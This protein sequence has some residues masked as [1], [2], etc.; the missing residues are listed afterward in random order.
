MPKGRYQVEYF[1]NPKMH[2]SR[3]IESIYEDVNAYS[4]EYF[5][6]EPQFHESIDFVVVL[7]PLEYSGQYAKGIFFS[8]GTDYLYKLHPQLGRLF[9]SIGNAQW[10]SIPWSTHA[11]G[12]FSL[13][14]NPKREQWFKD[15][16]PEK[17]SKVLVPLQDADYT[18]E[19]AMSPVPFVNKDIDIL[20]VSRLHDLKNIPIIAAALKVYRKKYKPIHMTM[21]LGKQV[22]LNLATLTD[23]ERKEWRQIESLLVHPFEYIT[24]VPYADYSRELPRYFSRSKL[25]VL[26]SLFEG[27]NRTLQEALCCNTPVVYFSEF[28]QYIRG[29]ASAVPEGSG[30]SAPQ[31]D[32]ES[33]ADTFHEVIENQGDFRP[34]REYLRTSGRKNFFNQTIDC[35]SHYYAAQLPEFQADAHTNNL[36]IDLAVQQ[37]YELSLN[38]FIYDKNH[39]LSRVRGVSA[40]NRLLEFYFA[41]FRERI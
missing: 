20:C 25:L 4:F 22:D 21:I 16:Y 26:G 18:H 15:T 30:L 28:N 3:S 23:G 33:L 17:S 37:S 36:W 19:Y 1:A 29:N 34:R 31:F 39:T 24:I 27:K 8:Q 35:F 41:R 7:P 9:H 14:K 6:D 13:Y 40:I 11:D 5:E 38:E 10:G 32:A 2:S 12:L